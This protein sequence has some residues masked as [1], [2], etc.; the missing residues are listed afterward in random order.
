MSRCSGYIAILISCFLTSTVASQGT[1]EHHYKPQRIVSLNLCADQYLMAI[2]DPAQIG[3][4]THLSRDRAMSAGAAAA[5]RLPVMRG[6][7]EEVLTLNPDLLVASPSRRMETRAAL[8]GRYPLLEL[9][10]AKSYADIVRQVR[11]IATAVGHGDRGEA[12]IRNMDASLA[13]L[14]P[15]RPRGVAAYYQRRGYLTGAGTLVDD[16]M[17]RMGLVNLATRLGKPALSRMSLEEMIAA[18]PDYIIIED[19]SDRVTDLGTE[20]LHHPALNGIK[21]LH[22]PQAWTVCG[23]PAY[24]MAAQSL[25][26]QLDRR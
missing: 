4:L 10:S 3:A 23:G 8:K 20:M 1:S 12:L 18:R 13:R 7:A 17:A 26:R 16:L 9:P 5:D 24:V 11:E 21:R 25:A 6:S 14:P 22:L 19:A 15:K 2:A